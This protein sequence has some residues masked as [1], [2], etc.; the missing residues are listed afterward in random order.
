MGITGSNIAGG[1]PANG[2]VSK[3]F[4]TTNPEAVRKF[5]KRH[6]GELIPWGRYLEPCVATGN[7]AD[8]IKSYG[9]EVVGVDIEDYGYPGT[10]VHDFISWQ[11]DER[12]DGIITNPPFML[13]EKFIRKSLELLKDGGQAAFFLKIQFLE[14]TKRQEFFKQYPPKYIYVNTKRTPTW[15]ENQKVNPKTG[16]SW[17]TT[18]CTAWYVWEKGF[19]GEPTIRW[20]L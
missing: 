13:A 18:M 5:I 2:R 3:D 19:V 8:V 4:Y 14:G 7:I 10:I 17:V 16:K 15:A 6:C 11:T 12:F 9:C 20:I 1:N